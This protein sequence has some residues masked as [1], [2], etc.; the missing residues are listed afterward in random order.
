VSRSDSYDT[1]V[2]GGGPAGLTAAIAL[3]RRGAKVALFDARS[4]APDIRRIETLQSWAGSLLLELGA[5]G[6]IEAA[7]AI[8]APAVVSNWFSP[9]QQERPRILNPHGPP[10]HIERGAFRSALAALAVD[11]GVHLFLGEL[12]RATT[13]PHGWQL[14]H[15]LDVVR[16]PFLIAAT[17]RNALPIAADINRRSVDRLVAVFGSA[18]QPQS[19]QDSQLVVEAAANG[20][21]YRC[22][23]R[24]GSQ[25]IVFLSDADLVRAAARSSSNWFAKRAIKTEL[26]KALLVDGPVRIVAANTYYRDAVVGDDIILIGDA[27]I[28]GDPLAGQGLTWALISA[29]RAAEIVSSDTN[30][31]KAGLVAYSEDVMARF[32]EFLSSRAVSYGQVTRWPDSPFWVRRRCGFATGE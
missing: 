11:A 12:T 10:L 9:L 17:G 21:W 24:D 5:G 14:K 16:S 20:W 6:A 23:S 4:A 7:G 28:A 2:I 31:R 13:G 3:T 29:L 8:A 19:S 27:A 1:A 15:G 26:G 25:Q 22:P 18:S 30:H 32:V